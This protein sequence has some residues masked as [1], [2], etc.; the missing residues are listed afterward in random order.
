[1]NPSP[2]SECP[3][4][5]RETGCPGWGLSPGL[6]RPRQ[7]TAH[8]TIDAAV[9][10]ELVLDPEVMWCLND[11]SQAQGLCVPR[12]AVGEQGAAGLHL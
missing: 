12:E 5:H 7:P 4:R 8:T 9:G 6:G 2:G 11:S 1:M 10:P 3:E